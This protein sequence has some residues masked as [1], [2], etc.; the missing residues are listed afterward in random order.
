MFQEFAKRNI[1]RI[2][3]EKHKLMIPEVLYFYVLSILMIISAASII[4]APKMYLSVG[5]LFLLICFSSLL[6][7]NL[8]AGYIALFQFLL[9]GLCL[10]VYI[11]LLLKKIGRLNLR[12]K[13]VSKIKIIYSASAVLLLSC[14]SCLFFKEE[15]TNSLFDIFNFVTVKTSDVVDFA[16][17]I[18]PL[19]LIFILVLISAVVI[20]VF[21][22]SLDRKEPIL[23]EKSVKEHTNSD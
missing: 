23:S 17:H 3:R 10:F 1:K 11:F 6:Y 22:L 8:N 2:G 5:S 19:H 12:L 15:F 13:L 7:L 16:A 4:A 21:L 18:F 20:R 14:L 9:C